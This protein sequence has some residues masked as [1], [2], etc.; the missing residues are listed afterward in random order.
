MC[1]VSHLEVISSRRDSISGTLSP[2]RLPRRQEVKF[3]IKVKASIDSRSAQLINMKKFIPTHS[4][5]FRNV[6]Q[7]S[8]HRADTS[9]KRI[10]LRINIKVDTSCDSLG[11]RGKIFWVRKVIFCITNENIY[12]VICTY[13]NSRPFWVRNRKI[14]L[15]E[16]GQPIRI[17]FRTRFFQFDIRE[18]WEFIFQ[19]RYK[20]PKKLFLPDHAVIVKQF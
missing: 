13:T 9:S 1:L 20:H 14:H 19:N 7:S 4:T 8:D 3:L 10:L 6:F 15:K 5:S 18:C 2:T 17:V 16:H 12:L 11:M